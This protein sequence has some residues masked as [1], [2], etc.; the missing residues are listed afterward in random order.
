M[1]RFSSVVL[2]AD[3]TVSGIEGID[4]LAARRGARI[5]ERV[6]LLTNRAMNGDVALEEIYGERLKIIKPNRTDIEALSEAYM[7]NVA[8]DAG[9][10]LRVLRDARVRLVLV[11]GGIRQGLLPMARQLGFDGGDLH[12]V[13]LH[14]TSTGDYAGFEAR[15]PLVQQ[16]GKADIVA[17]LLAEKRLRPPVLAVGDGATDV[18]MRSAVDRFAAFTGFVRRESVVQAADVELTSFADLPR[19]VLS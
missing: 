3:S 2:D 16:T 7:Q 17:K 9:D 10:A 8:P 1:T 19:F 15:S 12:A 13:T 6:A 11:S 5:A 14:F 4:W 18:M